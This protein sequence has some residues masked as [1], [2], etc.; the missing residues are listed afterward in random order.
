MNKQLT[1]LVVIMIIIMPQM[2]V[3]LEFGVQPRF[4]TGVQYYEYSQD[5]F[6]SVS[7]SNPNFSNAAGGLKYNDFLPFVNAGLT[8]FADKLFVD[9]FVQYSFDGED[10]DRFSNS[11]FLIAS[12]PRLNSDTVISTNSELDNDFERLEYSVSVGYAVTDKFVLFAGYKWAKTE[13]EADLR[14]GQIN[15]ASTNNGTRNPFLSGRFMGRLDQDIKYDGPFVGA[16]YVWEVGAA[17]ALTGNIAVAFM[18]GNVDFDFHDITQ[19]NDMGNIRPLDLNANLA[20]DQNVINLNGD[21]IGVSVGL[22]WKGFTPVDGLNYAIGVNG[23]RYDFDSTRST[24]F[25][26]TVVRLDFGVA[27]TF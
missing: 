9:L 1:Q 17:G 2:G 8:L 13:F 27:Y 5:S 14:E 12:P 19:T 23:Y 20:N 22:T 24:D 6:S 26:E 21:T 25:T 3:A 18:D 7:N 11:N 4:N 16:G 15:A 10:E